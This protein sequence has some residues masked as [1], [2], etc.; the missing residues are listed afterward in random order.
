MKL[1]LLA[2]ALW[3]F[4]LMLLAL[5][6]ICRGPTI[7]DRMVGLDAVNTLVVASMVVLSAVFRETW[8]VDVAIVYALLSYVGTL[9]FARHMGGDGP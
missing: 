4:V 8:L 1:L 3:L 5:I 9:F 6:R 2:T 7:P